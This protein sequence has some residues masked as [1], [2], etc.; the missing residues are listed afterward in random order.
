MKF[1]DKEK[2]LTDEFFNLSQRESERDLNQQTGV[3]NSENFHLSRARWQRR[4]TNSHDNRGR[5]TYGFA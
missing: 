5:V 4:T 2:P 3:Q 1:K